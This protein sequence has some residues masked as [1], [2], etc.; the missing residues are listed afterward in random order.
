MSH[1]GSRSAAS[2]EKRGSAC[3]FS[4][5]KRPRLLDPLVPIRMFVDGFWQIGLFRFDKGS[6]KLL[7][8]FGSCVLIGWN[9][10]FCF[11][12]SALGEIVVLLL[13]RQGW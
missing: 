8:I 1:A 2:V 3:G 7:A 4:I 5:C 10:E 6:L 13:F 12:L 11:D 9:I